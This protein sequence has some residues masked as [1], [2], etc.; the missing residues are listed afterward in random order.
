M[1]KFIL[2]LKF[3]LTLL[4][5]AIVLNGA[6]AQV[7]LEGK[8]LDKI[9]KPASFSS[10]LVLQNDKIMRSAVSDTVGYYSIELLPGMYS[11]AVSNL[12][13]VKSIKDLS[14]LKDTIINIQLSD[15]VGSSTLGEV[16][17]IAKKK[18]IEIKVD[19]IVFNVENSISLIGGD[20]LDAIAKAPGVR[21]STNNAISLIGKSSV[22]VMVND[23]LI[24]LSGDDLIAYLKSIPVDNI[25][26]LEVITNPPSRYDAEG[27]SGLINIVTKKNENE[28]IYGNLSAGTI[29]RHYISNNAGANFSYSKN[30]ITINLGLNTRENKN[31]TF[32]E[33]GLFYPEN[34]WLDTSYNSIKDGNISGNFGIDYQ[35]SGKMLLG[36]QY[37][38]S[39]SKN[40]RFLVSETKVSKYNSLIDSLI[41]TNSSTPNTSI[42]H[43]V[44]LHHEFKIDSA[45]RKL[46][47]DA[48]YFY[49][50]NNQEQMFNSRATYPNQ[51]GYND[52]PQTHQSTP[53]RIEVY[54]MQTEF[55][56]P[57][58]SVNLSMGG[59]VSFISNHSSSDFSVTKNGI[60]WYDSSRS[61]IFGYKE[62]TQALFIDGK[63]EFKKFDV[64]L[65]LR[66]EYT[67]TTG[68]SY[69]LGAKNTNLYI[70]VFPTFYFLL[71]SLKDQSLALTYGKR[72]DRPGY[73][74]LNPFRF[75]T[76]PFRYS[77]GN[78]QLQPSYSD[79][80]E[81]QHVFKNWLISQA[82]VSFVNN[83]F[84]QIG[85][86]DPQTRIV[87]IIQKNFFKS[88]N[89]GLGEA[90]SK[91]FFNS[92]ENYTQLVAYHSG[93]TSSD[94]HTRKKISGWSAHV[95]TS[96]T[97]AWNKS[98]TLLSNIDF[99]YQFPAVDGLDNVERYYS[100][101]FGFKALL[102]EKK[103]TLG[104]N[105]TDILKTN[106][107]YFSSIINNMKQTNG[108]YA[109]TRS[110][111]ISLSYKFGKNKSSR[112]RNTISNQAE[113][114]RVSQ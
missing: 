70:K 30:K 113:K 29:I 73:S 63:K 12:G 37:N 85:I 54:S 17:V 52:Y 101:D 43:S 45:G 13:K 44:N 9:G 78:P 112:T 60:T 5:S 23:R 111:R 96:N 79:N 114:N 46:F 19:R 89:Y 110:F 99:W 67:Q 69:T 59:K 4:L 42:T 25:S 6:L 104:L 100:L 91:T 21:V 108:G 75:Y 82:L 56:L 51:S 8:I 32:T 22:K 92:L 102:A 86:P 28:G 27:N 41:N 72:I 39:R 24:R 33:K 61:F 93:I 7:K 106:R 77:E 10:I 81:V 83:G 38:G 87:G 95:S 107:V 20:A 57:L 36:I 65:G 14:L 16:T 105:V 1:S 97:Y 98:K 71:K 74:R 50:D 80:I 55:L 34:K 47:T 40:R 35:I 48:D 3:V 53:Q 31:Y 26:R 103:L 84:D 49:Y 58:K 68:I 15:T 76:N 64:K 2:T 109:G 88:F 18:L 11:M 62:N 94:P 66:G 90:I